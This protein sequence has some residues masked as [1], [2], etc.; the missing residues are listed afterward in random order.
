MGL[1]FLN[2][3]Q[4][5]LKSGLS[6][7]SHLHERQN[8]LHKIASNLTMKLNKKTFSMFQYTQLKIELFFRTII[9]SLDLLSIPITAAVRVIL[10][11]L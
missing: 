8:I 9:S 11:I 1:S 2:F 7:P 4:S 5:Y 3:G 10:T 6:Y